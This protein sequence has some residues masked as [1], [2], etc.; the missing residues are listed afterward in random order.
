MYAVPLI[1]FLT[2]TL[3]VCANKYENIPEHALRLEQRVIKDG[4]PIEIHQIITEDGYIIAA[5]RIPHGLKNEQPENKNKSIVL[6]V[7]GMAGSPH[8]FIILGKERA[9]PYYFA[10]RGLDVWLFSS[11]AI[12]TPFKKHIQLDWDKDPEFWSHS[13]HELGIYDMAATID[14]ILN[15]TGQ[16]K[17]TLIGHSAGGTEYYALLSE[18]PEYNQKI[19]LAIGWGSAAILGRLD[20]PFLIF[21]TQFHAIW[22]A[23]FRY[24]GRAEFLP[25]L[26]TSNVK[27]TLIDIC[28]VKDPFWFKF[29]KY[30]FA[31]VGS[32]N[33]VMTRDEYYPLIMSNI[34][35]LSTRQLLHFLDNGVN[36]TFRKYDF[37]PKGNLKRYGRLDPPHYNLSAVTVPIA[38]FSSEQDGLVTL[39]DI[40]ES[41]P[42]LPNPIFLYKIPFQKFSHTDYI[43]G[44]YATEL[45][46]RPT[47]QMIKK[48]DD[49][50]IPPR[51]KV[52][53]DYNNKEF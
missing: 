15:C 30:T 37:G 38:H 34:P 24:I 39:D 32:H 27:S 9:A 25:G 42:K 1:I 23:I 31:I 40:Y 28:L 14:F 22:K 17:V 13:F 21:A 41:I 20:Y 10:D 44:Y 6:I 11:R 47:Y 7:H 50:I 33:S 4:Y 29:I 51:V 16:E 12:D 36:G 45:V 5:Y 35:R 18:K 52:P 46:Y 53:S 26:A 48:I 2:T 8:N 43:F 19:K 49:G 3:F